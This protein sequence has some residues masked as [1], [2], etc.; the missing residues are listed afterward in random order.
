MHLELMFFQFVQNTLF[1]NAHAKVNVIGQIIAQV[2]LNGILI[3][4][5]MIACDN[6][7]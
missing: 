2:K 1:D 4:N 7:F 5:G 3:A 6:K